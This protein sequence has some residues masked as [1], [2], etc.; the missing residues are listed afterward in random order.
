MEQWLDSFYN[1]KGFGP[2][3][4]S[5]PVTDDVIA[6]YRGKLPNTVLQLWQLY[7]WSAWGNGRL[8]LVNP[9]DWDEDMELFLEPTGLLEQDAWHV[10]ARSAFGDF[11]L[12]GEKSGPAVR[13][14]CN[15][16]QIY[17]DDCSADIAEIGMERV[18][19]LWFRTL[20]YSYC[21]QKD[22]HGQNGGF[23]YALKHL[24]PLDHDMLYG[25]VPALAL[26]GPLKFENLQKLNAHV[27][28][29]ILASLAEPEMMLDIG[30]VAGIK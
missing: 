27:H 14:K 4:L 21:D 18:A 25:F 8:W 30:K 26:G 19:Q 12:W 15:Y 23:D 1:F 7:G 10:L 11:Y 2:A 28:L 6:Q 3:T 17:P 22:E 29:Q 16:G 20:S 13:V 24:G 9:A 5:Q